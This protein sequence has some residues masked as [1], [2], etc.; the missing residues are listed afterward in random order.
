MENSISEKIAKKVVK[1]NYENIPKAQITLAKRVILDSIGLSLWGSKAEPARILQRSFELVGPTNKTATI[2]TTGTGTSPPY[3]AMINGAM[4]RLPEFFDNYFGKT[5]I[6]PSENVPPAIAVGEYVHA[7]GKDF[8]TSFIIG[9]ELHCRL[10]DIVD[11]PSHGFHFTT[12]GLFVVPIIVGKLLG[13]DEEQLVNAIGLSGCFGFTLEEVHYGALSMAR[14]VAYPL[15]A[16]H[17]IMS[18]IFAQNG[19]T[20]QR[21]IFGR[22]WND[23]T[24]FNKSE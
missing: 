20:G 9:Y 4:L 11:P 13:L 5:V 22:C 7:T 21:K 12:T 10:G 15:A 23:A 1:L 3:A 17:G 8:L 24:I 14:T 18:A 6:H 2:W 16:Q 19:F